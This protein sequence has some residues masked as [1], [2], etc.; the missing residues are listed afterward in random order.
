Q[1][2]LLDPAKAVVDIAR[3]EADLGI[4]FGQGRY[5]G[6][7]AINLFE[8]E[9]FP[10][11]SPDY[12]RLHPINRLEDLKHPHLLRLHWPATTPWQDWP[13]WLEAAGLI[14]ESDAVDLERRGTVMGDSSLLLRAAQEGQ[15]IGLGQASLV[16]DL[17]NDETLVAPF[18]QRLKTGFGYY[19]VYPIG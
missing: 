19:L 3:G 5:P 10:V 15:G 9:I 16:V 1:D 14:G 18:A 8:D 6:L 17:I 2:V 13:E 7:E 11:C 12:L 4:R